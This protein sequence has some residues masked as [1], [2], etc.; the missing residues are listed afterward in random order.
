[1]SGDRRGRRPAPV[2]RSADR[3]EG[4]APGAASA[5]D[6]VGTWRLLTWASVGDDG[7]TQPM[8]ERPHGVV[9]YTGDGTMITTIGR[10][11]RPPIDGADIQSGPADQRVDAM[12]TFIAYSGSFHVDGGDVVHEV[13]MSLYPNWV[14]TSQRRH[15]TLSTDGNELTLSADPVLMRGRLG[16]NVLTWRRVRR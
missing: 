5:A 7:V 15:V 2:D 11:D 13:T 16:A 14:G 8:G 9:V 4:A 3:P 1:M 6:L 10:A 12:A